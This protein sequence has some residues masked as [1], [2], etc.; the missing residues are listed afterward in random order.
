MPVTGKAASY[1]TGGL[2]DYRRPVTVQAAGHSTGS[3]S[4]YR[5]LVTVQAAGHSTDVDFSWR[6]EAEGQHYVSVVLCRK[7]NF[8]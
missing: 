3:W 7:T 6:V 2:L 1:S 5:Q 8:R 4:Q